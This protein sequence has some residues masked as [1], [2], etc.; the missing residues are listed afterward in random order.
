VPTLEG[1]VTLTIPPG[2]VSGAKLRLRN[3]GLKK[4]ATAGTTQERG[5][6]LVELKIV[7]PKTL[8]DKERELFEALR[9][10]SKFNPRS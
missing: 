2:A 9:T 5:D 4:R 6:L 7:V 1:K 10:E 8:T 3:Q